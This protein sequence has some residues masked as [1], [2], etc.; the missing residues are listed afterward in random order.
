MLKEILAL[1]T[2]TLLIVAIM[3]IVFERAGRRYFND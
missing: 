2:A 1:T 3:V